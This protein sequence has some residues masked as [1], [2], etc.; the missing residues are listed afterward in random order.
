MVQTSLEEKDTQDICCEYAHFSA[1]SHL[2]WK[3]I[4]SNPDDRPVI[5]P[6]EVTA[7]L[8]DPKLDKELRDSGID[9]GVQSSET[10]RYQAAHERLVKEIEDAGVTDTWLR[11][12][13]APWTSP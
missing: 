8:S 1:Y 9:V 13:R 10:A 6:D 5:T 7:H 4:L 12:R 11:Q 2:W 3:R